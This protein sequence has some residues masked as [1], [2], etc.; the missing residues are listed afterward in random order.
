MW[1]PLNLVIFAI[2]IIVT[3][4]ALFDTVH[5]PWAQV[6]SACWTAEWCGA[7][8]GDENFDE[9]RSIMW[10][11]LDGGTSLGACFQLDHQPI[12]PPPPHN[13]AL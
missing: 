9:W 4:I 10:V 2:H 3:A 12:P 7:A 8:G 1:P 6:T 13:H 5:H 11:R